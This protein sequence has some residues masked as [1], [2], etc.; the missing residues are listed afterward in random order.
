MLTKTAQADVAE[1]NLEIERAVD[2]RRAARRA[3][4]FSIAATVAI[5]SGILSL[6]LGLLCS[7]L[8]SFVPNDRSFGTAGTT[9]TML[10]IPFLLL[11]SLFL[12]GI[13]GKK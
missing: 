13:G 6:C 7:I 10:G 3:S 1:P 8:H 11:G 9:L 12:D 4:I 5:C 2:G